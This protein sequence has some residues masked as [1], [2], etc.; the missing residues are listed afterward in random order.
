MRGGPLPAATAERKAEDVRRCLKMRPIVTF[1]GEGESERQW[2]ERK[3]RGQGT[4]G[5][6]GKER[7]WLAV[8]VSRD[9]CALPGRFSITKVVLGKVGGA[10]DG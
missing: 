1:G 6:G 9:R 7:V 3:I 8:V 2:E 10:E 4:R 5:K